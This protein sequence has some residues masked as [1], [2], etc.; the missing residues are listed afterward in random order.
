MQKNLVRVQSRLGT[1]Q[2]CLWAGGMMYVAGRARMINSGPAVALKAPSK[3]SQCLVLAMLSADVG[4]L[5]NALFLGLLPCGVLEQRERGSSV[6]RNGRS[7][8]CQDVL[9]EKLFSE[10]NEFAVNFIAKV[11]MTCLQS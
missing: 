5:G 11:S 3:H 1:G 2:L 8:A 6:L 4:P 7:A 9:V 10:H